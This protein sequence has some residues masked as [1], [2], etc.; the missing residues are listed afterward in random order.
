MQKD[1]TMHWHLMM[2]K[3]LLKDCMKH[4]LMN[5]ENNL[6][7]HLLMEKDLLKDCRIH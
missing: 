1:L 6:Q 7:M 4:L 5:S 2:A 3:D